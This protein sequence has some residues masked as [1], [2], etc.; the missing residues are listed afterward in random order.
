MLKKLGASFGKG[1]TLIELMI[2]IAIIG[3]LAAIA[4]PN[5]VKFQCRSKQSEARS[6]LK[7]IYTAEEAYRAEYDTY[8]HFSGGCDRDC[9]TQREQSDLN[10][11]HF[12][13]KGNKF[14]YNYTV[15]YDGDDEMIYKFL[16]T[17]VG[18]VKTDMQGDTWT[19]NQN[20]ALKS[21]PGSN[22]CD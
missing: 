8:T 17:A 14:R 11:M 21:M 10:T 16:G 4:I 13:I 20:N 6:S 3:I 9:K 22:V 15:P 2:V 18:G 12:N 19:I 7:A 1:F 5:F